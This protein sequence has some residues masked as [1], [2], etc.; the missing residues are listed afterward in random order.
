MAS[1]Y[2]IAGEVTF[3]QGKPQKFVAVQEFSLNF[4]DRRIKSVKIRNGA[5]LAYDGETV[6][7]TKDITNPGR[8]AEVVIGKVSSLKAVI[9]KAKWLV[10]AGKKSKAVEE[11][12]PE[13][14]PTDFD[15]KKGGNFKTFLEPQDDKK[16]PRTS[17][18]IREEDRI[19]K[20]TSPIEKKEESQKSSGKL[21]VSGDQVDVKKVGGERYTV[22]SSTAGVKE[23]KRTPTVTKADEMGATGTIP[24][25]MKK[26][27]EQTQKKNAFTVDATTPSV[28][29]GASVSEIQRAKGVYKADDAQEAKVIKRVSK[30]GPEV[31]EVDGVTFRK[32]AGVKDMTIKTTVGSGS[33]PVSDIAAEGT[34]VAQ[35]TK[36]AALNSKADEARAKAEARKKAAAQTQAQVEAERKPKSGPQP[37]VK[38]NNYLSKLPAD[39]GKLHWVQKEKFVKSLTDKAFIEFILSVETI[40]AVLSACEERLKQLG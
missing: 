10:P 7:Y 18:I 22:T 25:T 23:T 14:E 32:T 37:E 39:W 33:T 38:D 8:P 31:Q 6:S 4:D 27:G 9:N 12:K 21:E 15:P 16:S 40:K 3:E 20:H 29:E 17:Q 11:K 1:R 30:Q 36:P 26:A 24:I 19:V 2:D 5:T 28:S 34:V 13:K 35:T